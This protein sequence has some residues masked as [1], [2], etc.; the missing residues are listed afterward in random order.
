[1]PPV[2]V[3]TAG[4]VGVTTH[5]LVPVNVFVGNTIELIVTLSSSSNLVGHGL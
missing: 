3:L 2:K 5:C 4:T 1:M